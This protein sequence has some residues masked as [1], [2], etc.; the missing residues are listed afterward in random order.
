MTASLPTNFD[1]VYHN[2]LSLWCNLCSR[3]VVQFWSLGNCKASLSYFHCFC[4][5]NIVLFWQR[6]PWLGRNYFLP[7]YRTP[8]NV[9]SNIC[10]KEQHYSSEGSGN[11]C[12]SSR[13]R[14][15]KYIVAS[16]QKQKILQILES[17]KLL[18][19]GGLCS[20]FLQQDQF[21]RKARRY[22]KQR[23]RRNRF[24]SIETQG[25]QHSTFKR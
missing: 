16:H 17:L 6:H 8:L 19:K 24:T 9:G 13:L 20:L 11:C 18:F 2:F 10:P 5:T 23:T 4:H 21:Y 1:K 15:I 25:S 12:C 22:N 3:Y 7:E 14:L